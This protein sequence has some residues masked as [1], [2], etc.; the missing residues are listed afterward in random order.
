MSSSLLPYGPLP[1]FPGSLPAALSWHTWHT[2]ALDAARVP[3]SGHGH[4]IVG[5]IL[6]ADAFQA[7]TGQPFNALVEPD[8][9]DG[10]A[11][12]AHGIWKDLRSLYELEVQAVAAYKHA[13]LVSLDATAMHVVADATGSTAAASP[14]HIINTL[15]ATY[16]TPSPSDIM[17]QQL[18]LNRPYM[19]SDDIKAHLL[20]H[21]SVHAF[22]VRVEA[23]M[24]QV[25]QVYTLLQSLLPCGIFTGTIEAFQR[26]YPTS[27]LQT[28]D[29]LA[30]AILASAAYTPTA[31]TAASSG[32]VL[33]MNPHA[34]ASTDPAMLAMQ[35]NMASM[36]AAIALLTK[37][38]PSRRKPVSTTGAYYCWSHGLSAFPQHTSATCNH[39]RPG[40]QALATA[41]NPLGGK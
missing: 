17:G 26:Q 24:P 39:P 7:L 38:R 32:Y 12:Y 19:S 22:L 14:R 1:A 36:A 8:P 35:Q 18:S 21:A 25:V 6:E 41:D 28:Y 34:S 30:A 33:H 40:H 3:F 11:A 15:R 37:A 2:A 10:N 29:L 13:L 20:M 31:V 16:G 4:G 23:E 27:Q 5:F 9:F